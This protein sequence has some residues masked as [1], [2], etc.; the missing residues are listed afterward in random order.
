[1]FVFLGVVF[2][3]GD[4]GDRFALFFSPLGGGSFQGKGDGFGEDDLGVGMIELGVGG[5]HSAY[6]F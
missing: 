6:I 3:G 5:S 4:R 2:V 1:M